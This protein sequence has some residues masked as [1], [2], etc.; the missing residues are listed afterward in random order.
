LADYLL[1][2]EAYLKQRGKHMND[3]NQTDIDYIESQPMR[4]LTRDD[5]IQRIRDIQTLKQV[6]HLISSSIVRYPYLTGAI[7]ELKMIFSIK[8]EEI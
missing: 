4:E 5:A 3:I 2:C 8:E 6:D 7:E 1:L